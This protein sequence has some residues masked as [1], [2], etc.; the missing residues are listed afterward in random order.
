MDKSFQRLKKLVRSFSLDP[1]A[2]VIIGDVSQSS[3]RLKR[4]VY[5][6]ILVKRS[7]T[8]FKGD[9]VQDDD[10]VVHL[11]GAFVVSAFAKF[12][13]ALLL[14]FA[15]FFI[16]AGVAQSLRLIVKQP[17]S[18][19]SPPLALLIFLLFTGLILTL[20]IPLFFGL[21]K[22]DVKTIDEEIKK[23]LCE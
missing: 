7:Y 14:V 21:D 18:V 16:L 5:Y 9:L 23:T 8:W 13:G 19:D 20:L 15:S 12:Q 17:D 6:G 2:T 1:A 4:V 3:V 11:V 22:S 10:G